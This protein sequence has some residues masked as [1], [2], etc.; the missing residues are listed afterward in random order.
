MEIA[1]KNVKIYAGMSEETIA[2]N[3]SVYVDGTKVGD[4]S[5]R[6]HGGANDIDVRDGEGRWNKALIQE[7]EA[8]SATHTWSYDGKTFNHSLDSYVGELVDAI[9]ERR[10]KQR[11][12]RGKT[13]AQFPGTTYKDGE[14]NVFKAKFT[15]DFAQKIRTRYGQDTVF[16]NEEL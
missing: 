1:L 10:D 3:A 9:Q 12:C 5:N 11:L 6:G 14:W 15:P 7:M 4:A 13:L 2:F 16:L 8:E